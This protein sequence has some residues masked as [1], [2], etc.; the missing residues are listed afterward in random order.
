MI[1]LTLTVVSFLLMQFL[2]LQGF[3][4]SQLAFELGAMYG[5]YVKAY[6]GQLWRLLTPIFVHFDWSHLIFNGLTLYFLG[7]M[8]EQ[9]WGSRWFLTLYLFAGIMGNAFAFYFTADSLVA[10]AS[11]SIFGLFAAIILLSRRSSNPHFKAMGN[12]YRNLIII[13]LVF[14]LFTPSVSLVGHLGGLIGGGLASVFL[15]QRNSASPW[16]KQEGLMAGL[17]YLFTLGLLLAMGL[18]F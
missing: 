3:S 9:I 13:N 5:D 4:S 18:F 16:T 12:S 14:N 1:L 2:Q 17:G 7:Q 6:P 10:G 15:P 8:A 11:G